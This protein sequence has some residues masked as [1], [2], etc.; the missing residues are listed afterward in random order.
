M[1]LSVSSGKIREVPRLYDNVPRNRGQ[2]QLD[3][4][5]SIVQSTKEPQGSTEAYMNDSNPESVHNQVG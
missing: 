2:P 3:Q 5:N 1:S 4:C